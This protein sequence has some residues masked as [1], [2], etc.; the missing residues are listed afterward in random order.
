MSEE[1]TVKSAVRWDR[2]NLRRTYLEQSDKGT[3][4][5]TTYCLDKD[6]LAVEIFRDYFHESSMVG[7][8][9]MFLE[10]FVSMPKGE[11]NLNLLKSDN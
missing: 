5:V 4:C 10:K 6:S 7:I 11:I 9:S 8:V 1:H 2:K 3:F